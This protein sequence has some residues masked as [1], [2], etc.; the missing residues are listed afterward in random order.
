MKA[1]QIDLSDAC[2]VD[3]AMRRIAIVR[4]AEVL[5]LVPALRRGRSRD[6]HDLRIACKRLRYALESFTP[7]EPALLEAASRLSQLQDALGDLHDRDLL[8]LVMPKKLQVSAARIR[9]EREDALARARALWRDAFAPYGPFEGLMRFT[10]L[11]YGFAEDMD[12]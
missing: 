3:D 1:R 12:N 10:G 5:T 7:R 8:L 11:G 9:I 4:F 6:L 2:G